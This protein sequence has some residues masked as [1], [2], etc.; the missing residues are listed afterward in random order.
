[1]HHISSISYLYVFFSAEGVPFV[2]AGVMVGIPLVPDQ[3]KNENFIEKYV[4]VNNL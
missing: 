2:G 4:R 1:M 3:G